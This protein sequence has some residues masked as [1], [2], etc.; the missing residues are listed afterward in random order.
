MRFVWPAGSSGWCGAACVS[1]VLQL[2]PDLLPQLLQVLGQ[3]WVYSLVKFLPHSS[4][5]VRD[6]CWFQFVFV[7]SIFSLPVPVCFQV[8]VCSVLLWLICG[9]SPHLPDPLTPCDFRRTIRQRGNC[10]HFFLYQLPFSWYLGSVTFLWSSILPFPG[11]YFHHFS[12]SCVRFNLYKVTSHWV[13]ASRIEPCLTEHL[14]AFVHAVSSIWNAFPPFLVS[15]HSSG[16][17]SN[18]TS[19]ISMSLI[20]CPQT[21]L[22]LPLRCRRTLNSSLLGTSAVLW[23]LY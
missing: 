20:L 18:I 5:I 9:F 15:I 23:Q 21:L 4:C 17:S 14:S 12:Y 7:C 1:V 2:L 13:S 22:L 11:F 10:F 6:R 8:L 16:M 19:F 3:E